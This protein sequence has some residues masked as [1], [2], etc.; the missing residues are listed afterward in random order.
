MYYALFLSVLACCTGDFMHRFYYGGNYWLSQLPAVC[1]W[2]R[3]LCHTIPVTRLLHVVM[4]AGDLCMFFVGIGVDDMFVI[5]SSWQSSKPPKVESNS[6]YSFIAR[7]TA[8]CLG[9]VVRT[10]YEIFNIVIFLW[11]RVFLLR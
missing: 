5:V 1:N 2:P 11:R 6:K 10:I 4:S 8:K 9:A 3:P 7:Y